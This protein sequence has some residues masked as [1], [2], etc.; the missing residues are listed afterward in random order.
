M[1]VVSVGS[2]GA[3]SGYAT[4]E[5][6]SMKDTREVLMMLQRRHMHDSTRNL[7]AARLRPVQERRCTARAGCT[8]DGKALG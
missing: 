3:V 1:A 5:E 7:E 2:K 4:L 6:K 8:T